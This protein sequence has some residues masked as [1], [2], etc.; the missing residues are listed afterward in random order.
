MTR[1]SLSLVYLMYVL[2]N[3]RYIYD[4]YIKLQ[5]TSVQAW[6]LA[7]GMAREG[8]GRNNSVFLGP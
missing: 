8:E 5:V 3:D 4:V 7:D 1:L 6:T 2:S